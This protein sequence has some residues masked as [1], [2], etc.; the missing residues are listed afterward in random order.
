MTGVPGSFIR[1]HVLA[2]VLVACMAGASA[3]QTGS[4]SPS[5]QT[6]KALKM[7]VTVIGCVG[8]AGTAANPFRSSDRTDR[9][10]YRLTG[11]DVRPYVDRPVRIVGWLASRRIRIVGG[12]VPSP[13]VA[14]HAGALDP[15]RAA[16]L[17]DPFVTSG[18]GDVQMP[19]LRVTRVRPV[20]GSCE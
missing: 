13:N 11:T 2:S 20:V 3:A 17:S 4:N 10:T 16:M 6:P 14:A 12:L 19:E 7:T 18:T 15:A 8:G 5:P 1:I 9:T